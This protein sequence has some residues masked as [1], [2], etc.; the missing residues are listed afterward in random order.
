VY[1]RNV[2]DGVIIIIATVDINTWMAQSWSSQQDKEPA[3][4]VAN[5]VISA[6]LA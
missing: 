1:Q 3:V 5:M 6:T 4:T 2:A